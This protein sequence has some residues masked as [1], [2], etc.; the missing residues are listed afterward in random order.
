MTQKMLARAI[1]QA[2]T[3]RGRL[4]KAEEKLAGNKALIQKCGEAFRKLEKEWLDV[5][6][7]C[8]AIGMNGGFAPYA[9]EHCEQMAQGYAAYAVLC[10]QAVAAMES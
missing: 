2:K 8:F 4:T 6:D 3:C 1:A 5:R 10:E 7:S 9:Q